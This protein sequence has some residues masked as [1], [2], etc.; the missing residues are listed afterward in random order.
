[1]PGTEVYVFQVTMVLT[2]KYYTYRV[3]EGKGRNWEKKND[4]KNK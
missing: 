3:Q 4:T 2:T 1:V